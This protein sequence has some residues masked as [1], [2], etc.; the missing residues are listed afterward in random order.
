MV[1]DIQNHYMLKMF[2][3]YLLKMMNHQRKRKFLQE[4]SPSVKKFKVDLKKDELLQ[5]KKTESLEVTKRSD[6]KQNKLEA[7]SRGN[8]GKRKQWQSVKEKRK[9]LKKKHLKSKSDAEKCDTTIVKDASNSV[10]SEAST[11]PKNSEEYSSNWKNLA[12]V[13]NLISGLNKK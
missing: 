4:K 2:S 8:S 10:Q 5:K 12:K 3:F 7:K 11:I 9:R 13:I 6:I 1:F